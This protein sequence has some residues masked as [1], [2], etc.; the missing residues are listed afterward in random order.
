MSLGIDPHVLAR[1]V[2]AALKAPPDVHELRTDSGAVVRFERE[3]EPGIE[4]RLYMPERL[5]WEVTLI[6]AGDAR[7]QRYP[8]GLPFVPNA[9]AVV[10]RAEN[11]TTVGWHQ[12]GDLTRFRELM[13]ASAALQDEPSIHAIRDRIQPLVERARAGDTAARGALQDE[14]ALARAAMS[15]ETRDS[16]RKIW[17][18]LQPDAD[19]LAE[20]ERIFL[21]VVRATEDDGWTRTSDVE[22]DPESLFRSETVTYQRN[23]MERS[24]AISATYGAI[25]SVMLW[26]QPL[27]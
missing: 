23:A 12:A 8:G 17:E 15:P 7:P 11:G 9:T 6:R 10:A 24:I 3:P 26:E 5:D 18:E 4:L 22:R 19:R 1:L 13:F 21:A 14:A 2:P 27:G 25:S 20:L 16:M